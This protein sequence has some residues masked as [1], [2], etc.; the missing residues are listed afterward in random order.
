MVLPDH[1]GKGLGPRLISEMLDQIRAKDYKLVCFYTVDRGQNHPAKPANYKS[2]DRIW[3]RAGF[4]KDP[5][6]IAY[7]SWKDIGDNIHSTKPMNVWTKV[8]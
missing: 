2:P 1:Q 4:T 5:S 6:R 7:F 8:I 3:E